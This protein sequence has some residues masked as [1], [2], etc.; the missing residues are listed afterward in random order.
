M[1]PRGRWLSDIS[2]CVWL[3]DL[4][5]ELASMATNG[6]LSDKLL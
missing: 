5:W 3:S 4:V 6:W 2:M 1:G